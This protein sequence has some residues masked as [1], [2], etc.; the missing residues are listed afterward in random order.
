MQNYIAQGW[1]EK[2]RKFL[3]CSE[4]FPRFKISE[5]Y[6]PLISRLMTVNV[7][8]NL[9]FNEKLRIQRR[10]LFRGG[11]VDPKEQIEL[12]KRCTRLRLMA[13][14]SMLR[15]LP[16]SSLGPLHEFAGSG[17]GMAR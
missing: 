10:Q 12:L 6:F 2:G 13:S 5:K 14:N 17:V 15:L 1:E 16:T 4:I 7:L 11:V 9:H 3:R 8:S